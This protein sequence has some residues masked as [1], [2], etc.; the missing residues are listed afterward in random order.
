MRLAG[1]TVQRRGKKALILDQAVSGPLSLLDVGLADLL[2]EHGVVK[3]VPR[4]EGKSGGRGAGGRGPVCLAAHRVRQAWRGQGRT[5]CMFGGGGGGE[6][7]G[8]G[9]RWGDGRQ[10]RWAYALGTP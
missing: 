10:W 5:H 8:K 7:R 6:G 4:A 1:W 3:C 2:T 9:G